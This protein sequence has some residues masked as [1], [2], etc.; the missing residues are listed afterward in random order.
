MSRQML[1]ACSGSLRSRYCSALLIALGTAA[2]EMG[3]SSNSSLTLRSPLPPD[4]DPETIDSR[5]LVSAGRLPGRRQHP[6]DAGLDV[7]DVDLPSSGP[8][9][10]SRRPTARL[11]HQ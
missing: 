10:N 9:P 6:V 3:L 8:Q 11:A 5:S 7:R 2:V 4:R 1:S